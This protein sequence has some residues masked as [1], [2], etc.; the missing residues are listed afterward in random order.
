MRIRRTWWSTEIEFS[1]GEVEHLHSLIGIESIRGL[2][3]GFLKFM[4][5]YIGMFVKPE[6]DK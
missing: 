2:Y 3:A 4:Y 6:E 1:I 5:E